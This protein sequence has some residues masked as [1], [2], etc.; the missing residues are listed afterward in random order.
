MADNSNL[1]D[2]KFLDGVMFTVKQPTPEDYQ[3]EILMPNGTYLYP[4]AIGAKIMVQVTNIAGLELSCK[5]LKLREEAGR[6]YA[7]IQLPL[8]SERPPS[9]TVI[10]M[11]FDGAKGR[12]G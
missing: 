10:V 1:R 6:Q 7:L 11:G 5:I 4:L 2:M 8:P 12:D 9:Q 3:V